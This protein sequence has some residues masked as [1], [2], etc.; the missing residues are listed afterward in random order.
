MGKTKTI[1]KRKKPL[2]FLKKHNKLKL[3]KN[4]TKTLNKK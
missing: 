4:H 3:A 2:L 1:K